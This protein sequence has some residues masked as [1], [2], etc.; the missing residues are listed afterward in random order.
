[1]TDSSP[2]D[3][4][5]D[6]GRS[7]GSSNEP[8]VDDAPDA[9]M[10]SASTVRKKRQPM[11]PK[12]TRVVRINQEMADDAAIWD[13]QLDMAM[14]TSQQ[15]PRKTRQSKAWKP[16]FL[17]KDFMADEPQLDLEEFRVPEMKMMKLGM[18][19]T[20]ARQMFR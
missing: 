13:L 7:D 17:T 15:P 12:W 4:A 11:P 1:M 16:L 9:S 20:K 18:Q 19:V 6:A 14:A 3:S 2:S 10:K 8:A 5:S